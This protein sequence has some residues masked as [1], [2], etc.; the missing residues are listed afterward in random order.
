[1]IIGGE[2]RAHAE[3]SF[4]ISDS[5]KLIEKSLKMIIGAEEGAMGIANSSQSADRLDEFQK[6]AYSELKKWDKS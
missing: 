2:G 3:A 4:F 6:R 5:G 1:M